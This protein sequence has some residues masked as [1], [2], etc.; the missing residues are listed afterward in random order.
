MTFSSVNG[1][2]EKVSGFARPRGSQ[3]FGTEEVFCVYKEPTAT[4]VI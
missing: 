1:H 4:E 3:R 2:W